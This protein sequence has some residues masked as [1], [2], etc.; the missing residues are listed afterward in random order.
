V[1]ALVW[2][3]VGLR[4]KLREMPPGTASKS[5]DTWNQWYRYAMVAYTGG[6]LSF[7]AYSDRFILGY[8]VGSAAVGIFLIARQ[9]QLLPGMFNQ[10][11]IM[12]GAPMFAAAHSRN[13]GTERQHIYTLMTDWVVRAS[14]PVLA[15]L[16]VFGQSVLRIFGPD[17][18]AGGEVA[19][20]I[21]VGAQFVNL[22]YGP[23]GNLAMMSGL[24]RYGL[25]INTITTCIGLALEVL[26]VPFF[27]LVGAALASAAAWVLLNA[28]L[29]R[30]IQS[31]LG[32]HWYDPRFRGWILPTT[33][34]LLVGLAIRAS[35]IDLGAFALVAILAIMYMAFLVTS[36]TQG[37]HKDDKD[38]LRHLRL[39]VLR[40]R[41]A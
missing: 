39:G 33:A 32:I 41:Y 20:V 1:G 14:L 38:L 35:G 24:E 23:V 27:G 40:W 11:L 17:F 10:M 2:M 6:L 30:A 26:F 12:V 34:M 13:D 7:T 22:A 29:L 8:F 18:A 5:K 3:G 9:L 36:I 25:R 37:L 19:L 16:A 21:L 31:H 4:R 15:F 28:F